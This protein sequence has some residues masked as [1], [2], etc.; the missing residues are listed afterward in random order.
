MS[1]SPTIA[2]QP[3][4]APVADPALLKRMETEYRLTKQLSSGASWFYWIA[5]LS[6]INTV[7]SL[8]G[9]TTSFVTGLGTTQIIDALAMI[10]LEGASEGAITLIRGLNI[11]F[12]LGAIAL[13]VFFGI[14]AHKGHRWAFIVGMVIYFFDSLI[15]LLIADYLSIAFHAL[16]LWGLFNGMKASGELKKLQYADAVIKPV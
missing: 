1:D 9:G 13:F 8:T 7:I 10:L 15:F 11:F 5:G 2:S 4:A 12:D 14:F 3:A 16:A 6:V